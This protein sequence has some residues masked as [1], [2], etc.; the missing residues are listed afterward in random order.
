MKPLEQDRSLEQDAPPG[1][2]ETGRGL[3][4]RA[5]RRLIFFRKKAGIRSSLVNKLV[6]LFLFASIYPF[7]LVTFTGFKAM[8]DVVRHSTVEELR[9]MAL[10]G[11]S[12]LVAHLERGRAALTEAASEMQHQGISPESQ[13][14]LLEAWRARLGSYD[15][16]IRPA[17]GTQTLAGTKVAIRPES[18]AWEASL[19]LGE[20]AV[21]VARWPLA[22]LA[23]LWRGLA[24][25]SRS[26]TVSLVAPDGQVVAHS[27]G[28]SRGV[29][30]PETVL[31]RL[32]SGTMGSLAYRSALGRLVLGVPAENEVSRLLGGPWMVVV[33]EDVITAH[34]PVEFLRYH[35][36]RFG[37]VMLVLFTAI[38]VLFARSIMKPIQQL[39]EGARVIGR[40]Q[41]E[42]RLAVKTGDEIELLAREFNSMAAELQAS[43]SSLEGKI[44][45]ATAD[46]RNHMEQLAD[47]R[48]KIDG[49]LRSVSDGL[50]V[51]DRARHLLLANPAAEA[52]FGFT[53]DGAE[54]LPMEEV[55]KPERVR[56]V[57]DRLLE[58]PEDE[59]SEEVEFTPP[60][61]EQSRVYLAHT[62]A[63]RDREGKTLGVVTLF[64]DI[65][66]FREL[67][68]MKSEFLSMAS[69]ELRTPLTSIQGFSELLLM[70][71]L[72]EQKQAKY[73]GYINTQSK[74]LAQL[75]SDFLDVA[76]IE[77][78]RGFDLSLETAFLEPLVGECVEMFSSRDIPHTFAVELEEGLPPIEMDRHKM[79]QVFQNLVGNAV[80]YSPDG[81]TIR[82]AASSCREAVLLEISDEGQGM[83][84]EQLKRIF[85]KF[86]R[87]DASSGAIEGTG[88]GMFIVRFI[89]EAHH[90]AVWVESE[91][92]RGTRVSVSLP[93]P[94]AEG[95]PVPEPARGQP[96]SGRMV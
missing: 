68:R 42:H 6:L 51:T 3:L 61:A 32:R 84:P 5:A 24:G 58:N 90:G 79:E 83:T 52:L 45:R 10:A 59:A 88:L 13:P 72:D 48:D 16:E 35:V 8:K 38:A 77:A 11:E 21:L 47:E 33:E 18:R 20:G 75:I 86:Y 96:T 55:I 9:T 57:L 25:R 37:L 63:V 39:T 56:E 93:C 34:R 49:I 22:D 12:L 31:V 85:D 91:E 67:D 76:R 2:Q 82:I 19:P 92:G 4:A 65:T 23:G 40:G 87:A 7:S 70:R 94:E 43:Y 36:M 1:A 28:S 73:L 71:R 95:P 81:G 30:M 17:D 15:M 41:L 29:A 26:V 80:K 60:G 46:L 78:G 69:H 89:V 14:G 50:V 44:D 66:P 74:R 62:A 54:G 53:L 27:A 64:S